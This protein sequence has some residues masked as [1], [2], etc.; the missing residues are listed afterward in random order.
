MK[1][2]LMAGFTVGFKASWC[3]RDEIGRPQCRAQE[4]NEVRNLSNS[5]LSSKTR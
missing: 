3:G 4:G 1:T 2:R 5:A